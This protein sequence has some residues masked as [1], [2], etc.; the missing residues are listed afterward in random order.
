LFQGDIAEVLLYDRTLSAAEQTTVNNYL[1][2]KYGIGSTPA[3]PAVPSGLSAT[4]G[5]GSVSVGWDAVTG[6]TGYR[7]SRSTSAGGP[8]TQIA[9]VATTTHL[10]T[11]LTNGTTYHYVV[12]AYNAGGESA[13]SGSVSATPQAPVGPPAGIP[14]DGLVL[15]LDASTVP[16]GDGALVSSWPDGSGGAGASGSGSARPTLVS[17]GIGGVPSVRFDGVDDFL[18]LGSGFE[19]FR[20]GVS[21]FVVASPSVLQSA[22]KLVALGNGAGQ[23][24]VVLGRAGSTAGLQYFTTRSNGDYGWFNTS[25]GLAAGVPAVYSAVQ[26]AGA[27]D[28]LVPASVLRNGVVIGSGNVFVPPVTNRGLN[29]IAK[30]YWPEPLFQGDIAEVLLYDRTLS[31]AEQTTVNNYLLN[32]YAI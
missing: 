18:S 25:S 3:V 1:L 31:A 17:S 10:D 29:Y 4:S 8:F 20:G 6:A 14:I 28:A 32:K 23:Q 26:G 22:S 30:S 2:N 9:D 13:V 27:A 15:A 12:T 5:D 16:G 11:G 7:V 24:N 21:M 19:D